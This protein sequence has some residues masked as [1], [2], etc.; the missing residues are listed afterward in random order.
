MKDVKEQREESQ[1]LLLAMSHMFDD[2]WV[3]AFEKRHSTVPP[4]TTTD[5][6][7]WSDKNFLSSLGFYSNL[8]S[9]LLGEM[10]GKEGR[11]K[12][13]DT[14]HKIVYIFP[15]LSRCPLYHTNELMMIN[16]KID[17]AQ[18]INCKWMIFFLFTRLASLFFVPHLMTMTSS[19]TMLFL[20]IAWWRFFFATIIAATK[21]R[22]KNRIYSIRYWNSS[23]IYDPRHSCQ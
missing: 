13:S 10:D 17:S 14:K 21:K 15:S 3:Y 20:Y 19:R 18:D 16:K 9:S 11:S 2:L 1:K 23:F 22:N 4:L 8:D 6:Y 12:N 7:I 5:S